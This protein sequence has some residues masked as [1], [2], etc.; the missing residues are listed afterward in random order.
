MQVTETL[1]EGLKRGYTVVLPAD[2]LDAKR[3]TRLATVGKDL[4]LPG[5]RPGKVPP[6]IVKQRFGTAISAEVLEESVQDAARSLLSE[7]G[8]RPARQPT[9][10]MKTENPTAPGT[11]VEFTLEM[12]VLPTIALPDFASIAL[13]RLKAEAPAERVDQALQNIA[14]GNRTL[15]PISPEDLAARPEGEGAASGDVLK[16]DFVGRIDG[17]VF[18]GG[19]AE[20]VDVEIGGS[21]FIPG[22]AEQ[23][24]GAKV[25][26]NPTINVTFP[27]DYGKEDLR[28]KA[29]TFDVTVKAI[30]REVL[31]PIDD[32]LATKVGAESVEK[33]RELI[34]T[35]IQQELDGMAR[36]RLKKLLLDALQGM[37]D[38]PVPALMV[39]EEFN[40]IWQQLEKAKEA[41]TLDEADKGKDD[42]TLKAEY[43]AI[44][45]RRVRLG[46]LLAEIGSVNSITVSEQEL[47]RAMWQQAMQ[48]RGQEMQM[49]E[50]FRKYPML[51]NSI[52]APL[53]E[54]KVVD[55]VLELA[56]IT[57]EVVSPEELEK[58]LETMAD[59][60]PA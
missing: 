52:R 10:T 2:N 54:D 57:D 23:L 22:F 49:L 27:D 25:G 16:V 24:I 26:E 36:T 42:E 51:T 47:D 43:R 12:E 40:Q 13:T 11:D 3:A 48:F 20:D 44:A 50:M 56:T 39:E 8:L 59:S 58:A 32:A 4:R 1:S 41:G 33:I 29:A 55:Y 9:L 38:F 5:F 35:R 14:K 60:T 21:G 53:M 45:E 31:P 18:E 7:R 34:A 6:A 30:N 46:L 19:S 17:E 15:E 28:S 37:V